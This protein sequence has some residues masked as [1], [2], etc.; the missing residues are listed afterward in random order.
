MIPIQKYF[1]DPQRMDIYDALK[2]KKTSKKPL[3]EALISE[4][5]THH[6]RADLYG[7]ASI[8][9]ALLSFFNGKC[10][11]CEKFQEDETLKRRKRRIWQIEHYRPKA[12]ANSYYW[13]GYEC[14][15]FLLS[16]HACNASKKEDFEVSGARLT[17]ENFMENG[18]IDFSKC[19]IHDPI[20]Q[21]EDPVFINP[22]THIPKNHFRF[23]ADGT[24][25]G[26]DEKGRRS[27]EIYDL[28]RQELNRARKKIVD[29]IRLSI[30]KS[31]YYAELGSGNKPTNSVFFNIIENCL[32]D[33]WHK[34]NNPKTEFIAFRTA[35]FENF[36]DFVIKNTNGIGSDEFKILY[37][38]DLEAAYARLMPQSKGN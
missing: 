9:K 19:S 15:N 7:M 27:I 6:F 8:E 34:I 24:I 5:E 37:L 1:D 4:K 38:D 31:I 2:T 22:V 25:E 16:C 12:G 13:L 29:N 23:K 3:F 18:T 32:S 33:L 28:D 10:A 35:I 30:N 14:T 21:Q 11:F 17:I 26:K 20:F 36:V